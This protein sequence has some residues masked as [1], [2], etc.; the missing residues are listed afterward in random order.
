MET[1]NGTMVA[2]VDTPRLR[3]LR[4]Q[5][6]VLAGRDAKDSSKFLGHADYYSAVPLCSPEPWIKDFACANVWM[7]GRLR[8][9]RVN[10]V[11]AFGCC[12]FASVPAT[13][14]ITYRLG[15]AAFGLGILIWSLSTYS[16]GGILTAWALYL[17]NWMLA[18]TTLQMLALAVCT[19]QAHC[20]W[21]TDSLLWTRWKYSPLAVRT[22]WF[23]STCSLPGGFL[24]VVVFWGVIASGDDYQNA[25]YYFVHG[26]IQLAVFVDHFLG[27]QP[28]I[29]VQTIW[30][31]VF[32]ASFALF[33]YVFSTL[34]LT[35]PDG[36]KNYIYWF[37][38]WNND[39]STAL[40]FTFV[41]PFVALPVA[42]WL[43]WCLNSCRRQ[44]IV[45][46]DFP[47]FED[48][49]VSPAPEQQQV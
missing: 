16:A 41:L 23:A 36:G 43:V 3:E 38:D 21:G 1:A 17:T 26:F 32:A 27:M 30:A 24:V 39:R 2:K 20:V 13:V 33:A 37:V 8:D 5:R 46:G 34:N 49:E 31:V 44:A 28:Y 12:R 18:L 25:L 48:E 11:R 6:D 19:L 40:L 15:L 47:E 35:N 9:G 42:S 29:F 4:R 14:W 45:W 10:W 7:E 22:A